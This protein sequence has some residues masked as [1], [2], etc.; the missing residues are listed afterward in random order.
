MFDDNPK[1]QELRR[2]REEEGYDGPLDQDLRKVDPL[3]RRRVAAPQTGRPD[4]QLHGRGAHP[5]SGVLD[6]WFK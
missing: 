4:R 3:D 5:A 2:I 6:D 1:Y